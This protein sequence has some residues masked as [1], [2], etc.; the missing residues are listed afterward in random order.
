M[1]LSRRV[2]TMMILPVVLLA[3][4]IPAS[5]DPSGPSRSRGSVSGVRMPRASVRTPSANRSTGRSIGR[6]TG[7]SQT[8]SLRG[9]DSANRSRSTGNG[10]RSLGGSRNGSPREYSSGRGQSSNR[11]RSPE[12]AGAEQL[13]QG[14]SDYLGA[15][16][17]GG[18]GNPFDY[19]ENRDREY[20]KAM[21]DAA[22]ADAVVRVVGIIAESAV[23]EREAPRSQY[24][25]QR[26]LVQE[27]HYETVRV[28]VPE[29][30]NERGDVIEGHYEQHRR[31][32]P[33][34][35][36]ETEVWAP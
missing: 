23:R 9:P 3:L 2:T 19:Y 34:V 18:S 17:N 22:I 10:Y 12:S 30:Q 31:W 16:G 14:L 15:Y 24:Q 21:R 28:W 6:N 33:P 4:G 7:R 27:G 8:R 1:K 20:A 36:Q 5:A 35:Y 25:T 32:V 11:A 26:V 13:L 29:Y